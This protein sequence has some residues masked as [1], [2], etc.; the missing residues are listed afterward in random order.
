MSA[1]RERKTPRWRM[2]R[3]CGVNHTIVYKTE[4]EMPDELG[5]CH[6]DHQEI[7][8]SENLTHE[9]MINTLLHEC[10]HTIDHAYGLDMTERQI[11]VMATALIAFARD[12][13][14]LASG[15]LAAPREPQ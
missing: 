7:W 12:N 8:L 9:S 14:E 13:P 3:I 11:N 2:A 10:L 4:R 1:T 6:S 5:Q 15:L